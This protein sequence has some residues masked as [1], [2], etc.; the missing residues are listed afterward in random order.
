M[1]TLIL[2]KTLIMATEH[3][4]IDCMRLHCR[5]WMHADSTRVR[6]SQHKGKLEVARN[7]I[8]YSVPTSIFPPHRIYLVR[9]VFSFTRTNRIGT[10]LVIFD[11]RTIQQQVHNTVA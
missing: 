5:P 10:S 6:N 7:R 11:S 3:W 9:I 4:T 1:I 2:A 8:P